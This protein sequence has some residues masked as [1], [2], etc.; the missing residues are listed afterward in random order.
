MLYINSN[1]DIERHRMMLKGSHLEND[2]YSLGLFQNSNVVQWIRSTPVCVKMCACGC[3]CGGGERI[4][5]LWLKSSMESKENVK[6]TI[7]MKTFQIAG[8]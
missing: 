7:L 3:V 8:I 6:E 4:L 2:M 1:D 5:S